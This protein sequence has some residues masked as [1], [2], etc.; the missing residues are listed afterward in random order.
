MFPAALQ[1]RKRDG[2]R[3]RV[4]RAPFDGLLFD[5]MLTIPVI[6]AGHPRAR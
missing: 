3:P 6:S 1:L 5:V 2:A 4:Y